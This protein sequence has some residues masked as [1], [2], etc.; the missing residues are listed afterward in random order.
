LSKCE[1]GRYPEII[2]KENTLTKYPA[3]IIALS[4]LLQ[5]ATPSDT[6][7]QN[8][9]VTN[10]PVY[11]IV[12]AGDK[13]YIGG[14]FT[15][16]GPYTGSGVPIDSSTGAP[17]AAFPKIN[18]TVNAVCDDGN[19]GWFVGGYFTS[20]DGVARNNI[21]HILSNG[22]LDP[23][24]NPNV[25]AASYLSPP[26]SV[27]SLAVSGT[28]VY[29]GG[30]F[31]TIG[32]QRRNY[33]AALDATT[34][35][36]LA[37]SPKANNYVWSLAV[38]GTTVYVGGDFDTIGGQ[39]RNY[40]AALDA[41]T[42]NVLAWSPK[43]NAGVASI[44]VIGTTVYVGGVFD[45]IGG[46]NRNYIAA[47]DATTGNATA[48]NPTASGGV[49]SIAVSGT[50]VYAGGYFHSI[51]GQ[52][53][54]GI[55]ALDATTGN[56]TAW[57]PTANAGVASIA[58][59]GTT[60]Y[61][62]GDFDTIGGQRR[63][64]IAA[65][66]ATTGNVL[67][68]SPKANAGVASIAVIGTT[69]YIGGRFTS[70]GGQSRNFIAA[71]DATT[72]NA[73]AWNPNANGGQ[74]GEVV[75]TFANLVSEGPGVYSLAVSGS[76][77]YAGGN[78]T[79]IGGQSRNN[80]AALDATTGNALAWNPNAN[81]YVY[82]LA[83][84]G[85]TVYAG[86]S[87]SIIG[88]GRSYI[89]ALD[90]ITGNTMAWN[91]NPY[92][93]T[94]QCWRHLDG[95]CTFYKYPVIV[96]SLALSG[97]TVYTAGVFENIGG[98]NRN[99]IAALDATTGNALV[100]NPNANWFVNSLIVNG[101]TIYAGGVF[102]SIGGQSRNNIAAL[103]ATTG[104][105]LAWNPDANGGPYGINSRAVNSLAVSGTT[106]YAGGQFTSI[107][108]QGRNNIVALD[109]TTGNALP[110]NPNA[111][112]S[113][114]SLAVN[115]TTVYVGGYFTNI[116]QGIGHSYFAQFDSSYN[117]PVIQPIST[118]P[119]LNNAMLKIANLS[120]SKGA[121]VKFAYALPKAEH[122]SLRVYN[123]NGQLL[124]ELVNNQQD[125]GNYRLT[126]Q[127]GNLAAGLYMVVF[128]AGDFHQEKMISLMK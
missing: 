53:R 93:S 24:W 46:Q 48:W 15:Q 12:P 69:V 40:I 75:L 11:A 118:S 10:G 34:G 98:Q 42:G 14:S 3:L 25:N 36:V 66:D 110:W 111:N 54:S 44:A 62:G 4:T 64:Y 51:G 82:S 116:G 105:A 18:G 59:S 1:N 19:G 57:N 60:V 125:A 31:D 49:A 8:T 112:N 7:N 113:V 89:A 6:C 124:S 103:D 108:G 26:V 79:S 96:R 86:G 58:V 41:T 32:G 87:G 27:Y 71:L 30:Y 127:K 106:V 85:T 123:I 109:A 107:G 20:V 91:P 35:N 92:D 37:W 84:S 63:N 102:L 101:A 76:T 73:L 114:H 77:V 38:S 70:I 65:L 83:V 2:P 128:K 90:A 61:V 78:F 52:G 45:S 23:A 22:S 126:M 5:A 97:A 100:W 119:H 122:V 29:A 56:A 17:V 50:T 74:A 28:T 39:R 94:I 33:I 121:F 120:G 99:Y 80:I 16:V 47:L 81:P 67:A 117:A 115:G 72:G 88:Q 95:T 9:W 21:A 68:W 55:A 104:N 43:A 13:V